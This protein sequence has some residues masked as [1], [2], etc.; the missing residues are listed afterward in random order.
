VA[1][2]IRWPVDTAAMRF[3]RATDPVRPVLDADKSQRKDKET[4]L[5]MWSVPLVAA[6]P[7]GTQTVSVKV[8]AAER[9]DFPMLEEVT[10]FG[11]A[12]QRYDIDNNSGMSL[13]ADRIAVK[14]APARA[15]AG[16]DK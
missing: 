15:G 12:V 5:P 2:E 3:L 13:R 7:G 9:P 8:A 4:G 10:P 6:A 14:H 1:Q 16:G 11:L